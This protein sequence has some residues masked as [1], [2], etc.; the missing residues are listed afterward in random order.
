MKLPL[1]LL[2]EECVP[3][4]SFH[5]ALDRDVKWVAGVRILDSDAQLRDDIVYIALHDC[6]VTAG[7]TRGGRVHVF[8]HAGTS[9]TPDD[10]FC[11]MTV[12]D[13]C[14]LLK[15]HSDIQDLFGEFQDWYMRLS[16]ACAFGCRLQELLNLT[17]CMTPN[18]VYIADMSF[19]ILAYMDMQ[20][21]ADTS[22]TWRY[23]LAHGYL[24]VRVMK[25][26]IETKEFETLNGFHMA[27]HFF[28]RNFNVPFVTKNIFYNNRPQA[29]LFVV[30]IV[31]RPSFR[32]IAVAQLLGEF[33]EIHYFILDEFNL[34]RNVSNHEAFF[35]DV[36]RGLCT[37]ETVIARQISLFD[38]KMSD[39]YCMAIVRLQSRDDVIRKSIMYQLKERS[40]LEY[41]IYDGNLV[42]LKN[43]PHPKRESLKQQLIQLSTY[44]SVEIC[45]GHPYAGFMHMADQYRLLIHIMEIAKYHKGQEQFY[46]ASDYHLLYIIDHILADP[47]LSQ[48]CSWNALT[49][50]EHDRQNDTDYFPT[51]LSYLMN[52]RNVVRTSK[53]LHIHRNTLMYR[54]EKI[55]EIISIDEEKFQQKLQ[56][57]LSMLQLWHQEILKNSRPE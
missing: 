21:M 1:G 36:L 29:H 18:H 30:N 28:S 56:M 46:E 14:N 12:P 41:F 3:E 20:V 24:P 35:G 33:A 48:L 40:D 13:T 38:W 55:Y 47:E 25:G 15:L 4:C 52:D 42:I 6:T 57:L 5:P 49:L 2:I 50:Q 19:K 44:Y 7:T 23:Q 26:M 16:D 43:Q 8:C 22:A 54:L 11:V 27:R 45:L 53:A 34:N 39:T 51:Y 17:E 10:Q 31:Q 9:L 32:D 37:D